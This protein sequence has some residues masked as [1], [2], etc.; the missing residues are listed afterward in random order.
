MPG[1]ETRSSAPRLTRGWWA[2]LLAGFGLLAVWGLF[3]VLVDPTGEFGLSGRF[4][5]NR[6]PPPAV[7]A[8][9]TSG[10]NPAFFTRAIRESPG[11]V[12]LIGSSRTWRGFDTCDRP[13]VLRVAGSAWGLRE[14]SRVEDAILDQRRRP[15]TLLIEV[16]LPTAEHPAITSPAQAAVSTALSPRTTVL[17]LQTVVHSLEG[18]ES[19]PVAY[20]PCRPRA[21]PAQDWVEAERSAR[22][23]L[24]GLDTSPASLAEGRR[25]LLAMADRADQACRRTRLRHQLVFFTLP[26]SPEASP[27]TAYDRRFRA[28]ADRLAEVFAA[29]PSRP[30]GC[31]VRYVNFAT[32]PP[33]DAGQRAHWADRGAWSDYVHFSPALGAAALEVLLGPSSAV[34]PPA[35]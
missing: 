9:G 8:A 12:F 31:A 27:F 26:P 24:A 23:L 13:E 7:I 28:N 16:G 15:A 10:N 2:G 32:A 21:S 34:G 6:A 33:G 17:S 18:G 22:Y 30:G 3:N 35:A 20:S 19:G 14:L 5:F 29:R 11:D 25:D 4:V 1:S